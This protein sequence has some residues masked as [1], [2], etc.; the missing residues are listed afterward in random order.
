MSYGKYQ[1]KW[2]MVYRT[3]G[4]FLIDKKREWKACHA[5]SA[6]VLLRGQENNGKETSMKHICTDSYT[7][8]IVGPA[9]SKTGIPHI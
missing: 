3:N 2:K 6:G 4:K 5:Q 7:C 8:A 1:R 9:V